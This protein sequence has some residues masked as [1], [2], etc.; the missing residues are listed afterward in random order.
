MGPGRRI[1]H[2]GA[3]GAPLLSWLLRPDHDG[4]LP[5]VRGRLVPRHRMTPAE[6]AEAADLYRRGLTLAEIARHLPAGADQIRRKLRAAGIR[7]RRRGPRPGHSTRRE[8][9]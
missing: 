1:V 7:M 8:F 6:I 9:S 5:E 3:R 2:C 4:T